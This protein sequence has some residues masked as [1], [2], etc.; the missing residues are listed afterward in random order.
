MR[1]WH[2]SHAKRRTTGDRV[3]DRVAAFIGSWKFI[4]GQTAIMVV[5]IVVNTLAVFGVIRFD[6]YPFVFLN[7]FMSAEAAFATPLILMSQNRSAERDRD[8]AQHD[9]EVNVEAKAEIEELMTTLARI[10][11]DKLDK[12]IAALKV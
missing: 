5:W 6:E 8:H 9:Y 10:E 11:N 3:A 12:I 4:I 2:E 7:L 1:N